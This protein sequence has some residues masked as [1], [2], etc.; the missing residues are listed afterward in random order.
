MDILFDGVDVFDVLLDG[1]RVVHAEHGLPL[2]VARDAEIDPQRL[3]MADVEVAVGF[4]R[5]ACADIADFVFA[6]R[7]VLIDDFTDKIRRDFFSRF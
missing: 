2:V 6:G 5:E 3:R 7:D 1:I 4:W